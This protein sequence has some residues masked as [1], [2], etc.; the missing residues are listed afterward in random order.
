MMI[1]GDEVERPN[2]VICGSRHGM[3]ESSVVIMVRRMDITIEQMDHAEFQQGLGEHC[4]DGSMTEKGKNWNGIQDAL[5][6]MRE[7]LMMR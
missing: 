4:D 7:H 6:D 1:I 5:E 3:R 2:S